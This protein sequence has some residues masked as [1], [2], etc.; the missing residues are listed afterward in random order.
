MIGDESIKEEVVSDSEDSSIPNLRSE[1]ID[2]DS[3]GYFSMGS[4][5]TPNYNIK[6]PSATDFFDIDEVAEDEVKK[7]YCP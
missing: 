5:E 7:I 3:E 4:N 2:H 6:S 1:E